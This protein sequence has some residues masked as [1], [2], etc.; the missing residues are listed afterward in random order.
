MD[1]RDREPRARGGQRIAAVGRAVVEVER[2]RLAVAAQ[3]A[4]EEAEHV[5]L[6][7]GVVGL[8]R[9]DVA[10][11]VVEQ[12]VDAQRASL[13][14]HLERWAVADVAVPKRHRA[15]GLPAQARLA[16][17]AVAQ[18][19]TVEPRF[20]EEAPQRGGGSSAFLH[21]PVGDEGAEDDRHRRMRVLAADVE[22][23]RAQLGRQR[24]RPSP[25]AARPRHKPFQPPLAV[26][27]VPA[28]QRGDR[29]AAGRL[30]A[31]WPELLLAQPLQRLAQRSA[32][33]LRLG[34]RA[35]KP[36]AEHR[37]RLVV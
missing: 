32:V 5:D 12:R 33:Q 37:H 24:L 25:V 17:L 29:E 4:D 34:E 3:G 18:A 35:Q 22:Q 1:Q 14:V 27:V 9:D 15:L 30:A 2:V 11:G 8:E 20:L 36:V 19:D 28:L 7:L 6:A 31:G 13:A 10:G 26:R 21:P 16:A 23:E